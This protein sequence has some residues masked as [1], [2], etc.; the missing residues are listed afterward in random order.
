LIGQGTKDVEDVAVEAPFVP[1]VEDGRGEPNA[2]PWNFLITKPAVRRPAMDWTPRDGDRFGNFTLGSLLQFNRQT[3]MYVFRV[4]EC[5]A[6]VLK[7]MK[8]FEG[9][10][11]DDPLEWNSLRKSKT[12]K[13]ENGALKLLKGA[14]VHS[15]ADT[16]NPP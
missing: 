4:G 7:L 10:I 12:L 14:R 9:D 1:R 2:P 13:R 5:P 3:G 11:P 16:L 15:T 8:P 6:V